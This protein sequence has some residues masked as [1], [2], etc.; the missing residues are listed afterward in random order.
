M[1]T[2]GVGTRR[3]MTTLATLALVACGGATILGPDNE[4]QV[5]NNADEFTWRASDLVEVTD[6]VTFNWTITT[7]SAFV[8]HAHAP[9][10]PQGRLER[11]SHDLVGHGRNVDCDRDTEQ[12]D[13]RSHQLPAYR[14]S[15]DGPVIP[16]GSRSRSLRAQPHGSPHTR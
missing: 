8:R 15:L 3:V 4:V 10:I 5:S 7:P 9:L 6:T 2:V 14:H 13:D 12:R 1:S 11:I 16:R